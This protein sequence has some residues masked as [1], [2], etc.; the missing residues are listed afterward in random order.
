MADEITIED[1]EQRLFHDGPPCM[2]CRHLT[3]VGTQDLREGWACRAYPEHIPAGILDREHDHSQPLPRDN[4]I[5]FEGNEMEI[6][7]RRYVWLWDGTA[8]RIDEGEGGEE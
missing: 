8:Q 3:E 7:G 2:T 6:R 4:G 1:I 5:M